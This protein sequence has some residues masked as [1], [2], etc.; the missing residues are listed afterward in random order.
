MKPAPDTITQIDELP[1]EEIEFGIGDPRW[2][3]RTQAELYSDITTA[4]IREYSTNAWDAHV[5]AGHSD[6]IEVTLPSAF[7]PTFVVKDHG[8]GMD[9]DFFKRI[10]TQFGVSDKRTLS[11]TNGM[12]GYGSKSGVAYTTTFAVT[13]VRDGIKTEGVIMRKPDWSIVLKVVSETPTTEPNGTIIS[14]PVHNIEEFNAKAQ[15]FY[16]FWAPGRV[17]V[18]G[19]PLDHY[20]GEKLSDNLYYSQD[21][22]RSYVVMGNVA[23]RINNPSALFANS[24]LA[25]MDFVAYIDDIHA[26][27]SAPVDFTPSREDLN[28]T[29]RT[30]EVLQQ[31]IDEFEAELVARIEA[32]IAQA[33]NHLEAYKIWFDWKSKVGAVARLVFDGDEFER[34]VPLP[35]GSIKYFMNKSRN[36]TFKHKQLDNT[37]LGETLVITDYTP[38]SVATL[39]KSH[40][41]RY[42][43][44]I[45]GWT[46]VRYVVYT[47][48]TLDDFD[49]PW[50]DTTQFVAWED[51]KAAIP[52]EVR[53]GGTG[54]YN[55]GRLKGS[56]DMYASNGRRAY[57]ENIDENTDKYWVS[58]YENKY[59]S[60][61][62]IIANLPHGFDSRVIIV[63]ANR[64]AKFLR[65]NP[66]VVKFMD[67]AKSQVVANGESLVTPVERIFEELAYGD[68]GWMKQINPDKLL[69][70]ELVKKIKQ[71][72][73]YDNYATS[74]YDRNIV[75][76]RLCGVTVTRWYPSQGAS[77]FANYP[78]LQQITK[79]PTVAE[80][81]YLYMNA[82]YKQLKKEG[83]L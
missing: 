16:K 12:L 15:G 53:T 52:K 80:E 1:G 3:M 69:D 28:Y 40:A 2:V 76:G 7:E 55:S 71:L 5:M 77:I 50:T 48:Q 27:G 61:P 17:L 33:N 43:K 58:T 32:D 62:S 49:S 67:Y 56:W 39:A 22:N 29:D 14:I 54:G 79:S 35:D 74:D 64:E 10:Y 47:P 45:K 37:D 81:I 70:K 4:I 82:K 51:V 9:K 18:N 26:D 25:A 21:Y 30:K 8:V 19:K 41:R 65:E 68:E 34:Y 36:T 31:V 60:V 63:P 75:L 13:S 66:D 20:V 23:Y 38:N 6:P 24:E 44:E 73:G 59:Y 83:K 11:N 78:L 72:K 46:N 57:E 42:A